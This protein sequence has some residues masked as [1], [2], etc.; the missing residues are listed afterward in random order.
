MRDEV[1]DSRETVDVAARKVGSWDPFGLVA[2]VP[3]SPRVP[4][5]V[6]LVEHEHRGALQIDE[7]DE[8]REH[9]NRT[10]EKCCLQSR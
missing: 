10:V 2:E 1:T 6:D 4:N 8:R 3:Q 5:V 9:Q 7:T